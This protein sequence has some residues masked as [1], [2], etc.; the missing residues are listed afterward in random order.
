MF[1][2]S[3]SFALVLNSFFSSAMICNDTRIK[4]ES[5]AIWR[6]K[7]QNKTNG[8][9]LSL[10]LADPKRINRCLEPPGT[11]TMSEFDL[12]YAVDHIVCEQLKQIGHS[13]RM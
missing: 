8:V 4:N 5:F 7:L 10:A 2:D 6:W 1:E 12:N 13:S 11:F 9:Q 3:H